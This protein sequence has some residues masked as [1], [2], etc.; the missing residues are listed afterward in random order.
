V[1]QTAQVEELIDPDDV[2]AGNRTRLRWRDEEQWIRSDLRTHPA[3]ITNDLFLAARGRLASRERGARKPR[4]SIHPYAL[5]GLVFCTIC[6]RRMEGAWR[7]NRSSG[8]GRTLYRCLMAHNRALPDGPAQHPSCLYVREDG[9]LG[10]LDEWIASL[11]TSEAIAA[12]QHDPFA[13]SGTASLNARLA[14]VDRKIAALVSAIEAGADLPQLTE[15]L[16]RRGKEREGIEAQ[17]RDLP[18]DR[19]LSADDIQEAIGQLGGLTQILTTAEPA[20]RSEVYKSLGVRLEYDHHAQRVT[21]TAEK[22]C[23][24]NRVRRGT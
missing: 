24:F 9:I 3:L 8:T 22:A 5:Q 19:R 20:A 17:I 21:V 13:G 15:Q 7:G 6:G 1:G 14:E 16:K 12:H 2:A 18:K 23:V 10:P 11:T 4:N